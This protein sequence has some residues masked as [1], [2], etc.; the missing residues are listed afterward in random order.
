MSRSRRKTPIAG[1]TAA[2]SEKADKQASHRLLRRQVRPLI[3]ATE[4]LVLPLERELTNPWSMRKDGK[5]YFDPEKHPS[6]MRK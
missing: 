1:I 4:G 6:L 2:P 3:E 5:M